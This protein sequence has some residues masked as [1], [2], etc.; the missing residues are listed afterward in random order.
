M[1]NGG[2]TSTE[3]IHVPW[4]AMKISSRA[5]AQMKGAR[6]VLLPAM[7]YVVS[8]AQMK[9][10]RLSYRYDYDLPLIYPPLACAFFTYI[11]SRSWRHALRY[12]RL[13]GRTNASQGLLID[14]SNPMPGRASLK[15]PQTHCT[16]MLGELVTAFIALAAIHNSRF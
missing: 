12:I 14:S 13:L 3:W 10:A 2:Y 8:T 16:P 15:H 6:I 1:T 7:S 5:M 4:A 11:G 9:S